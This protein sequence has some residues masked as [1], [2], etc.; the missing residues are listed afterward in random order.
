MSA[1]GDSATIVGAAKVIHTAATNLINRAKY[2][3]TCLVFNTFR[4]EAARPDNQDKAQGLNT[5][6]QGIGAG[7]ASFAR[8]AKAFFFTNKIYDNLQ[9]VI[10]GDASAQAKLLEVGNLL[11]DTNRQLV[12]AVTVY[13]VA[14]YHLL[15]LFLTLLRDAL[16]ES[17]RAQFIEAARGVGVTSN[18]LVYASMAVSAK[19]SDTDLRSNLAENGSVTLDSLK[20][21][22]KTGK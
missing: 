4:E 17:K 2:C 9:A 5:L 16:P 22:M 3:L 19:P 6:A 7:L 21:F 20:S 14:K 10:S 15:L 1:N 11:R 13:P 12:A 18:Q 8:T